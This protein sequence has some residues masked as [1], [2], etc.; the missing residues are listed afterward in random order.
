MK[1]THKLDGHRFELAISAKFN[2]HSRFA[3]EYFLHPVD[4]AGRMAFIECGL[5]WDDNQPC[6]ASGDVVVVS[7]GFKKELSIL[8][9]AAPPM[10]EFVCLRYDDLRQKSSLLASCGDAVDISIPENLQTIC[11]E[12][13]KIAAMS[14]LIFIQLIYFS[15]GG[16]RALFRTT[17]FADS[18]FHHRVT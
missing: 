17:S 10:P 15:T 5:V 2:E 6:V 9:L 7:H 16:L 8:E 4:D 12:C 1:E 3:G 18:V 11:S 14:N 13:A